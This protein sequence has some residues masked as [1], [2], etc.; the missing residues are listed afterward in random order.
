MSGAMTTTSAGGHTGGAE[1]PQQGHRTAW[2][3]PVN[4]AIAVTTLVALVLRGYLLVRPGVLTVTQYDDGPYFGSAV[5]LV[6]GV[7][8]YR[9]FAFV[10]PPGI[11]VLLSPVG[12][13]TYLTGTAWGLGIA[14]ILTLLAGSAAVALTGLLVRH[15]GILAVLLACGVV[16]IYPPAANASH[17]VLLEPWLVLFCLI[18]AVTVF[19]GDRITASTRRLVWG[20]VMFGLAGAIKAWAIVPVLVVA[21]LCVRDLRRAAMFAAGVAAGF[22]VVTLPFA[23]ASPGLFYN[24][25]VVAQLARIGHRN[26]VWHRLQS[27][28]GIPG[29]EGWTNST[30]LTACLALVAFVI[31]TQAVSWLVTRMPPPTLDWFATLSAA[32]IVAIFLWPPY[33]AG[34]YSAFLGPF[35]AIALALPV[36]RL[37]ASAQPE[38]RARRR[39]GPDAGAV[40]E[41]PPGR[42]RQ[43][44]ARAGPILMGVAII[45]G[46]VAQ[47]PTG[48]LSTIRRTSPAAVARV[49]PPGACVA[50]DLASFLLL[51]NR[52]T[53][54]VPGCSQ[55]VDGLGTDL[56]L[57][58]GRRPGSGASEVPAVTAAWHHAFS[59]ARYVL[60]TPENHLRIPWNPQLRDYF[61]QN[62]TRVLRGYGFTL[63]R[64]TASG[65]DQSE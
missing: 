2:L 24:D 30:L 44:L 3:S 8:P 49:V 27:M 61:D 6:H 56:A 15:R 18:G 40:P 12:L 9:D 46:A 60:L 64:R 22:L 35:L 29:A 54:N 50:T 5:R 25:V 28:I 32:G 34:H 11:T 53:S 20:G 31:L 62:F 36:S 38:A 57:S 65:T 7:L 48:R 45:A 47:A 21:A 42:T 13:L 63:Y 17:T 10:Q 58:R 4:L 51:A 37:V 52:F 43:L 59:E 14:R 23:A 19:D 26:T 16:A 39:A 41:S 33:F 1:A 55:M